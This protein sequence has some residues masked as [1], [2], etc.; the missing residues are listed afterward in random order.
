MEAEYEQI[1][2][3]V[4]INIPPSLSDRKRQQTFLPPADGVQ[5]EQGDPTGSVQ[6]AGQGQEVIQSLTEHVAGV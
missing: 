4:A 6:A 1:A 5:A 2:T 3:K